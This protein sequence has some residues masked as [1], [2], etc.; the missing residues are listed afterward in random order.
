MQ[1]TALNY[2]HQV[3]LYYPSSEFLFH[4]LYL[5]NNFSFN[6]LQ[7]YNIDTCKL[8]KKV[9]GL[10]ITNPNKNMNSF[11]IFIFNSLIVNYYIVLINELNKKTVRKT[12]SKI[13]SIFFNFFKRKLANYRCKAQRNYNSFLQLFCSLKNRA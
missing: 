12:F 8:F 4:F 13:L 9:C 10:K 5:G 11:K 2:L 1:E 7:I 6:P 3:I